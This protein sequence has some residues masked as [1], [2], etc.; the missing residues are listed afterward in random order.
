M[1]KHVVLLK[2]KEGYDEQR[3]QS[4]FEKLQALPEQIPGIISFSFGTQAGVTESQ[5]DFGLVAE[6]ASKDDCL[7]YLAHPAHV[8]VGTEMR[9]LIAEAASIQFNA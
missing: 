4:L 6:F 5:Y 8:A 2:L 3:L 9:E 7:S 1:I